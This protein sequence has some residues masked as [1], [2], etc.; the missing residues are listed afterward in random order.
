VA[1]LFPVISNFP[2]FG[3]FKPIEIDKIRISNSVE[4]DGIKI[5]S[6]LVASYR[7]VRPTF[8]RCC[9]TD[10]LPQSCCF[11]EVMQDDYSKNTT[12]RNRLWP[13]LGTP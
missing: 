7:K 11:A 10:A 1:F 8:L 6:L 4:I 3:G 12:T 5:T 9:F 2:D 13:R